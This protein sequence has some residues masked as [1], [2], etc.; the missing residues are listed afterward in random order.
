[1]N[2]KR[3]RGAGRDPILWF[4]SASLPLNVNLGVYRQIFSTTEQTLDP[5]ALVQIIQS[6]QLK[7]TAPTKT[8]QEVSIDDQEGGVPLP[9]SMLTPSTS[10]PHYFLCM[11]GG[12]HFAAMIIS[13]SPKTIR[14]NGIEDRSAT[15][16]AHKTFHR[17]TTR[18][19]QGGSQSA[20]D[21]AKGAAHSAGSTLR[22]YNETALTTDIRQLLQEWK[23]LVQSSELWF[24]RA[25]GST[26]R[27]TLYGP[28]EGQVMTH[29]DDR[30]RGFPFNTRRATQAELMRAFVE[31]TRVKV[32]QVDQEALARQREEERLAT[33]A[34]AARAISDA[35]AADDARV[36]ARAQKEQ[37]R[38][39][40][41]AVLHTSQL[42]AL[43]RRSKAPGLISYLSSNNLDANYRFAPQSLAANHHTPFSLHLAASMN[44]AVC[45]TALLNKTNAD[46]TLVNSAGKTAF[47]ICGDRSTR[48]AF[49]VA[50]HELGETKHDWTAAKIPA[51]MTREEAGSRAEREKADA[52]EAKQKADAEA[53][54]ERKRIDAEEL[55]NGATPNLAF[56]SGKAKSLLSSNEKTKTAQEKRDDETRGMTDA[57]KA[58]LEREKRARAAEARLGMR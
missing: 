52:A 28:Y 12:G 2:A 19:K 38:K 15:V 48:D 50:R 9:A 1:M 29:T 8:T 55:A 56:K 27:R 20:N 18:R 24:V 13:L 22:R 44:S 57:M 35:Q 40:Q 23:T 49:R 34:A 54:A 10:G 53:E 25:T 30:I 5:S 3:K 41:E 7:P 51:A 33:G 16:I 45:V 32:V 39:D 14:K 36:A 43:I 4:K 26:N 42:Q 6:K 58:R 17:Y 11:M 37:D 47:E 46:P 31:L 21:N